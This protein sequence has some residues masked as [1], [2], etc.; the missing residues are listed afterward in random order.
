MSSL[1]RDHRPSQEAKHLLPL[2]R[3]LRLKEIWELHLSDVE[4]TLVEKLE[5][6]P[7]EIQVVAPEG[8]PH[9]NSRRI[10][11]RIAARVEGSNCVRV[12]SLSRS[13]DPPSEW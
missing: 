3:Y 6:G 11:W 8:I 2:C 10:C 4:E 1:G 7:E 12:R 13:K 9:H 5:V